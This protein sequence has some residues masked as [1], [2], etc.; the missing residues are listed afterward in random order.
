MKKMCHIH[1]GILFCHSEEGNTAIYNNVDGIM[2]SEIR[3]KQ[4][5]YDLKWV[6]SENVM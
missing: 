3:E 6:R 2:L 4:I 5:L 1:N